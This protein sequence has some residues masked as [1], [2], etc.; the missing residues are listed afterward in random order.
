MAGATGGTF[1]AG[2]VGVALIWIGTAWGAEVPAARQ[3]ADHVLAA[4]VGIASTTA[5]GGSYSGSG[6][7]ITPA[8]HILTTTSVVPVDATGIQVVFPGFV[9]CHAVLVATDEELAISLV[10]I[11]ADSL[12]SSGEVSCLA[13]ARE[14]PAIGTLAYT[15]S[16]VDGVLATNG[17]ASF[18]R[19]IVSG[20]YEVTS[21]GESEYRGTVIET[22]AAVNPGSDGGPLIDAAGRLCG[23]VTLGGSPLR[24]QGVAVPTADLLTRFRPFRDSSLPLDFDPP[25]LITAGERSAGEDAQD[26]GERAAA[27]RRAA[28]GV[29]P[30][31]VGIEV[32]RRFPPEELPLP[33]WPEQRAGIEDWGSLPPVEQAGRFAA[34]MERTRMFEVNQLL[35]RPADPVSGLVV[36]PAGLILTSLFSLGDDTAFVAK[37]TGRPRSFD[38]LAPVRDQL[39]DPQGGLERQ[40]NPVVSMTVILRDGQRLPGTLLARH[41]PLGIALVKVEAE[42]L[43]WFDLTAAVSSPLLGDAVAVVGRGPGPAGAFTINPGIVSAPSRMRGYQFQTD[44]LLNYG[45]SGGPVVDAGGNFLGIAAAPIEPD[46]VLGRL[47]SRAEL[48]RWTRAPNSGVGMVARADRIR[49]VFE[50]MQAGRSFDRIPGPYLGV[51]ADLGRAFGEDVFVG[52]VASGSPAER[53][54]LKKGDRLLEFDGVELSTWRDLTE[55]I[56]ASRAGDRITLVVQRRSRGPRLVIAGRDVESLADLEQLKK[57]LAPGETFEGVLSTEDTREVEVVLEESR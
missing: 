5:T 15:A 20:I 44:A 27:L 25:A 48:M 29:A 35:R 9:S 11:V 4:T 16:D 41:E 18:S 57:S 56:A 6:S 24:W 52:G 31:L 21:R 28:D 12:P 50:A 55:R 51:Q 13:V 40:T 3:V 32:V 10:Q 34:F 23:V 47:F 36:G 8:G 2:C 46:T 7:V 22:T 19:G 1:H 33:S 37:V 39:A 45:N 14:R 26:A 30:Y 49:S 17:R 42:G 54:G 38:S 53:A 43:D